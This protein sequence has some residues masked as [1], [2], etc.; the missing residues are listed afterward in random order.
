MPL[1]RDIVENLIAAWLHTGKRLNAALVR[2]SSLMLLFG[3]CGL[4]N[5][6]P[7]SQPVSSEKS[8][9]AKAAAKQISLNWQCARI[10][11]QVDLAIV[12]QLSA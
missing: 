11:S 2:L 6:A 9:A 5:W 7:E 12:S 4:R 10:V 8:F 3:C 1:S